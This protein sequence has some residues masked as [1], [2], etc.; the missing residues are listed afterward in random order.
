MGFCSVGS[1][2]IMTMRLFPIRIIIYT[3]ENTPN[4]GMESQRIP[5][6]QIASL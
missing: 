6:G 2:L 4:G 3:I 1:S 5:A